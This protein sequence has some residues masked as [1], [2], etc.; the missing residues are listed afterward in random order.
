[1][2]GIAEGSG[3]YFF[4]GADDVDAHHGW[5]QEPTRFTDLGF[6]PAARV[7]NTDGTLQS[8]GDWAVEMPTGSV[9]IFTRTPFFSRAQWDT[10]EPL[11]GPVLA[12]LH[13]FSDNI[14]TWA[15]RQLGIETAVSR[16]FLLTHHLAAAGRG[17]GMT[18][19]QRMAHDHA[20]FQRYTGGAVGVTDFIS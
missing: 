8:C 20:V 14:F 17:A 7:L 4:M 10:L 18:A 2:K 19:G 1:M 3:D 11:V 16:S 13:Y 5:W 15:G 6:L 12:D 9:P